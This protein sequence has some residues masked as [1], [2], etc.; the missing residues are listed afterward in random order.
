MRCGEGLAVQLAV[1]FER[2]LVNTDKVSR[3]HVGRKTFLQFLPQFVGVEG[4][5]CRVVGAQEATAIRFKSFRSAPVN[6]KFILHG[7][8]NFGRL[9]PV[10][11]DLDHVVFAPQKDIIAV[12]ILFC[13]IAGM[14]DSIGKSALCR[15]RKVDITAHIRILKTEL[16]GFSRLSHLSAVFIEQD[17]PCVLR[18][19]RSADRAYRIGPVNPEHAHRAAALAAGIDIDQFQAVHIEVIGRFTAHK[20]LLKVRTLVVSKHSCVRRSQ[21]NRIDLLRK[22]QLAQFNRILDG[23]IGS[24]I[25]LHLESVERK[26]NN[27]NGSNKVERRQGRHILPIPERAFAVKH[28]RI[29]CPLQIS[30]FVKHSLRV[31]GCSGSINRICRIMRIRLLIPGKRFKGHDA[32]P[33]PG[34]QFRRAAAVF[35][36]VLNPLR[37][38][39]IF[40]QRPGGT[41]FPDTDH[42]NHRHNATGQVDEDKLVLSDSFLL[43]PCID[44][45]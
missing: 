33:V 1:W 13:Q 30:V 17:D 3:D 11:V 28:D 18:E 34:I 45:A 2:D 42:G 35:A 26:Q 12:L 4:N 38:I 43:Q 20:Q 21:K 25:V 40:H 16:T 14:I 5:I 15:F 10:P 36:D 39:G 7:G 9:D 24:D 29:D 27:D 32:V 23:R 8:F 19:H 37:G 31:A 41:R 6:P 44:P 22:E